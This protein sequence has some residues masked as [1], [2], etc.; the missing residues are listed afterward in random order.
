MEY[1]DS[2]S[3]KLRHQLNLI[4]SELT[5]EQQRIIQLFSVVYEPINRSRFLN[6]LNQTGIKQE[7]GK[8][9]NS[10]ILKIEIE[11]LLKNNLI[12]EE[13]QLLRCHPL[14]AEIATRD[15][16]KAGVWEQMVETIEKNV[17]I[18]SY[19]N[20]REFRDRLQLWREVRIGIYRQDLKFIEQQ[21]ESYK[22]YTYNRRQISLGE[23][24]FEVL[25][26]PFD[27]NFFR[28]LPKKLY[29]LGLR[30]ILSNSAM[31]LFDGEA[32][33]N[34]LSQKFTHSQESCSD[35]LKLLLIEQYILRDDIE[36]AKYCLEKIGEK[37]QK[38]S[39]HLRGWLAFLEGNHQEAI[40]NYAVALKTF[41][42]AT[43]KRK[44]FFDSIAGIFFILAL[45]KNGSPEKLKQA[46]DYASI[47]AG[48]T[49]HQFG[50]IYTWLK[51]L[52]Q[53]QRGDLSQKDWIKNAYITP[54]QEHHSIE[55]FFC[56]LC[57]YWIDPRQAK[58]TLPSL[59]KP[60]AEQAE[61]IGY[62]WLAGEAAELLFRLKMRND[63]KLLEAVYSKSETFSLIDL[64]KP[65]QAWEISLKA[66][67]N[68][69]SNG[70]S[71]SVISVQKRLV[72][73]I[74][75]YSNSFNLEPRE[76]KITAQG[77]WSKGR[78]IALKR[79]SKNPGQFD[80]LT[81]QDLKICA[82]IETQYY[83]YYENLEYS[84]NQQ[85][86]LLLVGHPLVFWADSPQT[87]V[88]IVKGEPELIVKKAS[89]DRLTLEFFPKIPKNKNSFVIVKETP[90]KLKVIEI[91]P[92][93]ERIATILGKNNRLN[94]PAAASEQVLAAINGIAR[95]VTVHSDI[96]VGNVESAVE[97]PPNSQPHLHLLPAGEGLKAALLCRPF[98]EAGSYYRPGKGGTTLIT[99]IE[100]QRIQTH[101]EMDK[102]EQLA[103]AI[104]KACPT[105]TRYCEEDGEWLI[106][107]I[108][109]CLELLLEL[110]NLGE[111][112][113][114]EWPE[115]EKLQV[116]HQADTS[117]FK[118]QI[119][120]QQDWFAATGELKIDENLVLD[121]ENLLMLLEQTPSRFIPLGNGEFL[122]LTKAFRQRLDEL[123]ILSEKQGKGLR[124]HSLAALSLQETLESVGMLEADKHWQEQVRQL[125]EIKDW[126][127][128]LP[129]TLQ[130]SLRDYQLDG[131]A[132]LA[133]LAR[134]GVGACLADQ[135]GLGK[136]IQAIAAILT[137]ASVGPALIVAP[138]SVCIN[139]ISETQKFAPTLN[140]LQFS[141]ANRQK[142]LDELQPF[143]M[144]VCSYG[145]LQQEEVAQ[146]LAQIEWQM[147]VLDEAQAI[148]N[149]NTKR[150]R[151]A[152][153]LQA[154]FKLITTGT[155]IENHLGE[156]WNLFRFINPGLLGSLEQFNQRFAIPIEKNQDKQ[157]R[158][159]LKKLIQPFLLR[160]TKTQV[161]EELPTRTEITLH[162]ELSEP[163]IAF[164]EALRREALAKLSDSD[165]PAGTKHLQV[166]AEIMKLRRAC[167]HS[168]LVM[169]DSQLPSAKLSLFAEVLDELIENGHKA[170]V[171]SQFVDHLHILRNYLDRQEIAYQYLDGSTPAKQRKSRIDNFQG[172]SGDVFLIS[173]KAGG[174]GLN[175][176]A[177]D[178]VIHMDPWWNPAVEDQA[179]DRAHRIGQQR[180][181]TIY[182]LVT[183][184]TIEEKIV[185]LHRHKR[186]LA[187]SLLEGSEISA[188]M[189]TDELLQLITNS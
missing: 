167:C 13:K 55:T 5:T 128:V 109:D 99:E 126:Q 17:P 186:D 35:D 52:V 28:Q 32:Q 15:A 18:S 149:I 25:N 174:T 84:F 133:R 22:E 189:S 182:R 87:R 181:V 53:I 6:C 98:G 56:A 168:R 142:L 69:Q 185:A 165:A 136:T 179:S 156:L 42:K 103:N 62:Y 151:A 82:Q 141:S 8:T 173:L 153:K 117:N 157:V 19:Y 95:I 37:Q 97:V 76:Q 171:F 88:E 166:L 130:A 9:F 155:P 70:G 49:E 148:K 147:I 66:L 104:I 114:I 139:W 67:A 45:L 86:I 94:V 46:E 51:K 91:T 107:E 58:K 81:A 61:A 115:G 110:Q 29:E 93:H 127:P 79:L 172:G 16:I 39:Q 118:M 68:L 83:G 4:Y 14:M 123:R 134:W 120:R 113:I 73:L 64:V 21:L 23:I 129:S 101:R 12:I 7:N 140:P 78:P 143:D 1:Y 74:S 44:V 183:K 137:R 33:F 116:T 10:K 122:A 30:V 75:Y 43:G 112:I 132:W 125:K 105:L 154:Q 89:K 100:G 146:M 24:L 111:E 65:Q 144:L 176:T 2:A 80:Y 150:S 38:S 20:S 41:R 177:A 40:E 163:E 145:L 47:I 188:K 175:L 72:W 50:D 108:E 77:V 161:L 60:L 138:T 36:A 34:L 180:P 31:Y 54:N 102:E 124:F 184:D 152:M 96:G 160:R 159:Q 59:L 85:A 170:L 92:E 131:F 164:Y 3:V 90:T 106:T 187:D 169:P 121:M 11:N 158:K 71:Q 162:V 48:N 63:S 178:Y 27:P 135:M 26:N 57:L 119:G